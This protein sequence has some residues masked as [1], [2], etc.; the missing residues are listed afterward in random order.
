M[1]YHRKLEIKKKNTP[2]QPHT[3]TQTHPNTRTHT[4][5]HTHAGSLGG[6][7]R[8]EIGLSKVKLVFMSLD[9]IQVQDLH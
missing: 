4:H 2:N 1:N 3:H 9:S 5:T 8:G 7:M 6:R